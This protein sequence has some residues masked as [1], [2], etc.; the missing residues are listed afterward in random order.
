MATLPVWDVNFVPWNT[1][2]AIL[3]NGELKAF[4]PFGDYNKQSVLDEISQNY[5]L[6]KLDILDRLPAIWSRS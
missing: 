3:I 6:S 1:V 5:K 2:I 4:V